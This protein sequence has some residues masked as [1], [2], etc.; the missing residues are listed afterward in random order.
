[1]AHIF[2][3]WLYEQQHGRQRQADEND[4]ERTVAAAPARGCYDAVDNGNHDGGGE[5]RACIGDAGRKA[6]FIDKPARNQ[7]RDRDAVHEPD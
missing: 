5:S 3:L 6:P 7:Q 4:G 2:G 1:M